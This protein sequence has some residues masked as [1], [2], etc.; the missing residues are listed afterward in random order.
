[1]EQKKSNK[2]LIILVIIFGV[3][4]LGLSG[5]IVYDK[6]I[7]RENN[8]PT[9]EKDNNSN[10]S[11]DN[12][13]EKKEEDNK[14]EEIKKYSYINYKILDEER[15]MSLYVGD[16]EVFK[17]LAIIR[18]DRFADLLIVMPEAGGSCV[19]AV[20][21]N[22]EILGMF[23]YDRYKDLTEGRHAEDYY[24]EDDTLVIKSESV[25]HDPITNLCRSDVTPDT[26]VKATERFKYVGNGDFVKTEVLEKITAK[27]YLEKY[28][29]KCGTS[30]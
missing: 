30:N 11:K 22:G 6:L 12:N 25:G 26:I 2:V 10:K 29:L 16:K 15:G 24:I 23:G 17:E 4:I 14:T 8:K 7:K 5:F 21:S 18:V 27:E 20:N 19:T 1:M 13:A 28:N 3:I 9:T